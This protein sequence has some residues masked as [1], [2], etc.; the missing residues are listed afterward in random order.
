MTDTRKVLELKESED[1]LEASKARLDE[2]SSN[3]KNSLKLHEKNI[4]CNYRLYGW[5]FAIALNLYDTRCK[6]TVSSVF[7]YIT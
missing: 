4:I 2:A 7:L 1:L 3:Y 6:D 5:N